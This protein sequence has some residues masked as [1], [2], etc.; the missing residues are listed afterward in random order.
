MANALKCPGIRL[1]RLSETE[2]ALSMST[3]FSKQE[4]DRQVKTDAKRVEK[5]E[6]YFL[7]MGHQL[8]FDLPDDKSVGFFEKIPEE[9]VE[10]DSKNG[11]QS[12]FDQA[13]WAGQHLFYQ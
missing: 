13:R 8:S 10:K 11:K 9:P 3:L 2:I 4:F 6:D 12:K 7:Q 5:Q 1:D